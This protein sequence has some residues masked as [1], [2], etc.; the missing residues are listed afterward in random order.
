MTI[1]DEELVNFGSMPRSVVDPSLG[2]AGPL[3]PQSYWFKFGQIKHLTLAQVQFQIGQIA[4]AG[5]PGGANWL[6][7][8]GLPERQF[9]ATPPTQLIPAAADEYI[10]YAPVPVKLSASVADRP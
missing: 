9:T 3:S 6:R 5:L 7:V 2:I 4:M 8:S 10:S 1:G